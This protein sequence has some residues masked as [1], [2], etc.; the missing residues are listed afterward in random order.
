MDMAQQVKRCVKKILQKKPSHI[1]IF[2]SQKKGWVVGIL[3][4]SVCGE[5]WWLYKLYPSPKKYFFI[6]KSLELSKKR[7]MGMVR[8]GHLNS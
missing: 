7:N 8:F 6:R 2:F 5:G 3:K 1:R 4:D